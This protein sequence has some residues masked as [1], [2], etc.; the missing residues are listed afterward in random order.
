MNSSFGCHGTGPAKWLTPIRQ[1][2]LP[3]GFTV[4]RV[5]ALCGASDG[6]QYYG[7]GGLQFCHELGY[8]TAGRRLKTGLTQGSDQ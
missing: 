1:Q 7:D 4:R 8:E 2:E 3:A 5:E 6:W